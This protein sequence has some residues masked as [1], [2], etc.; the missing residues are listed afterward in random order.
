[1]SEV[2]PN[3]AP[4]V[5]PAAPPANPQP[6]EP[7]AV[8]P[9]FKRIKDDL[10]KAKKEKDDALAEVQRLKEEKLKAAKNWEEIAKLK[11]TEAKSEKDRRERL[12]KAIVERDKN[13]ALREEAVKAG[14]NPMSLQDLDMLDFSEVDIETTSS[15]KIIVHGAAQ[16]IQG[17]KL[18]RPH[19]F[20]QKPPSVN[21]HT[22][23]NTQPSAPG[24]MTPSRALELEKAYRKN[25]TQENKLA[26][27]KSLKDLRDKK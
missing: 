21:P 11:E 15:G 12:E 19:W 7:P 4:P 14:I 3:A 18:R 22:P 10:F 6:P 16:A 23:E 24:S 5:D 26:Y 13:L 20:S 1:M 2:D 17:L 27:E 8:D 25:P 9:A